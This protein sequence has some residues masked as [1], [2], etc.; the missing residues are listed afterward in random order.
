MYG[1][2]FSCGIY[3]NIKCVWF[4]IRFRAYFH[5]ICQ[6]I[7]CFWVS[8]PYT[9][10]KNCAVDHFVELFVFVFGL[11]FVFYF[12]DL[13]VILILFS[14]VLFVE[15]GTEIWWKNVGKIICLNFSK[16]YR[17]RESIYVCLFIYYCLRWMSKRDW[18]K[19]FGFF[20]VYFFVYTLY[21]SEKKWSHKDTERSFETKWWVFLSFSLFFFEYLFFYT[22][23]VLVNDWFVV[24]GGFFLLCY[25]S[26]FVIFSYYYYYYY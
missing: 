11:F 6:T 9:A 23:I 16:I 15:K 25:I 7:F 21:L 2:F 12:V 1:M 24:L 8:F 18:P 22:V 14:I 13:I 5:E 19:C 26:F 17:S 4:Y 3:T 10:N 20:F